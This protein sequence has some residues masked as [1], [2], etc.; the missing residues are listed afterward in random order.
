MLERELLFLLLIFVLICFVVNFNAVELEGNENF[1]K[2]VE[3]ALD[4]G[5]FVENI[6]LREKSLLLT[7]ITSGIPPSTAAL[8]LTT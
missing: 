8:P 7:I 1:I 5:K 2:N 4:I 3:M 6:F